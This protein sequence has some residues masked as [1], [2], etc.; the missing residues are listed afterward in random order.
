VAF[1]FASISAIATVTIEVVGSDTLPGDYN[2]DDVVDQLDYAVWRSQ[3][4][5]AGGSA[6]GNGDGYVDIADYTVWRDNLGRSR[7]VAMLA[8]SPLVAALESA[9]PA[10]GN[11]SM[12][13]G[14][15][16][17]SGSGSRSSGTSTLD[18][19][20]RSFS[21]STRLNGVAP[22]DVRENSNASRDEAFSQWPVSGDTRRT[23]GD[24]EDTPPGN[25]LAPSTPSLAVA[26]RV[27][28]RLNGRPS[29]R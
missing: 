3:F 29:R 8:S 24:V 10:T 22:I 23:P 14:L 7:G 15:D 28:I 12:L 9:A 25:R 20:Y 26:E 1:D 19:M 16:V 2:A 17:N 13:V 11:A 27:D 21:P 6:D 18:S 5:T 4:G